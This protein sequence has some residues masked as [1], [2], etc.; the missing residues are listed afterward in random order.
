MDTTIEPQTSAPQGP[1]PTH[2]HRVTLEKLQVLHD[3]LVIR[4]LAPPSKKAGALLFM[5]ETAAERERSH[6][7]VVLAIGP[8]DWNEEGTARTPMSI[9]PGALVFF[10]KYAGTEEEIGGGSVI[11]MREAEC[12]FCVPAGHYDVVQHP[13]NPKLAH[14]VEDWC[15]VCY[16]V[17]TEKAK[18]ELEAERAALVAQQNA[19]CTCGHYADKHAHRTG[20]C[21]D[22]DTCMEFKDGGVDELAP[23]LTPAQVDYVLQRR[24]PTV[25]EVNAA[26]AEL[27]LF[28]PPVVT[29]VLEDRRPCASEGC[30]FMQRKYQTAD[31][32]IWIG[33]RCGHWREAIELA[34]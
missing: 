5:A 8:G 20:P 23:A 29:A 26:I 7:G 32:P 30:L 21:S 18:T 4:P 15:D 27:R 1:D 9:A 2:P 12:R 25:A 31:G 33:L 17:P 34:G 14:L 10:G 6:R 19:V 11:V 13:E 16:G 24:E 28:N 3:Y 22:C